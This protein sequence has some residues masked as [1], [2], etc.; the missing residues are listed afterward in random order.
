GQ[1]ADALHLF[2]AEILVHHAIPSL[3]Q[4]FV[5]RHRGGFSS[6]ASQPTVSVCI[7]ST[8]KRTTSVRSQV[9]H[10]K[11]CSSNPRRPGEM[12]ANAIRCLHTGH[13]GRSLIEAVIPEPRGSGSYDVRSRSLQFS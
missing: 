3:T 11:V 12:R 10:S 9:E 2:S 13:I 7:G 6:P 4:V 5:E 1:S 8:A